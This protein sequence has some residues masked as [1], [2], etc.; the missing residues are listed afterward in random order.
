MLNL[1][2]RILLV[3]LL[4]EESRPSPKDMKLWVDTIRYIKSG[5]KGGAFGFITYMELSFV[6]LLL[7]LRGSNTFYSDL[8][9][10]IPWVTT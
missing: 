4:D 10:T 5:A 1:D 8:A 9:C 6:L 2:T 3:F 7:G